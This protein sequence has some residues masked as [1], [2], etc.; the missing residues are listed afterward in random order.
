MKRKKR[1]FTLIEVMVA[2]AMLAF[3]ATAALK[4]VTQAQLTLTKVKAKKELFRHAAALEAEIRAGLEDEKGRKGELFWETKKVGGS[5][6]NEDF[7]KLKLGND[8]GSKEPVDLPHKKLTVSLKDD[9]I[10]LFFPQKE[11]KKQNTAL[12]NNKDETEAENTNRDESGKT[13]SNEKKLEKSN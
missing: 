1:A 2:V 8:N 6:F 10:S 9:S 5:F 12:Q 3:T 13:N 7:G 11:E 4:L